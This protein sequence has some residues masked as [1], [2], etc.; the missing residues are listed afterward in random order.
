MP[1][2]S[3]EYRLRRGRCGR[4]TLLHSGSYGVT[5]ETRWLIGLDRAQAWFLGDNDSV[6]PLLDTNT[7]GCCDG[8]ELHGRN[9]NQG[10]ETTLALLSTAQHARRLLVAR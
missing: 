2:R 10:A 8:L 7:G 1:C 6:M 9:I 4:P 3:L 5:G